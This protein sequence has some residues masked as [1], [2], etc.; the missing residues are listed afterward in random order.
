MELPSLACLLPDATCWL[1]AVTAADRWDWALSTLNFARASFPALAFTSPHWRRAWARFSG[2]R[3]AVAAPG[4]A[5]PWLAQNCTY[6]DVLPTSWAWSPRSGRMI[7]CVF[8]FA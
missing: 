1:V 8:V 5:A 2:C 4:V 7:V 6:A 3:T